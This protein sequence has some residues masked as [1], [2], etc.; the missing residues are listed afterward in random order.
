MAKIKLC[1]C[2]GTII[3]LLFAIDECGPTGPVYRLS[4]VDTAT[5]D[6]IATDSAE[7]SYYKFGRYPFTLKITARTEFFWDGCKRVF[8]RY[9]EYNRRDFNHSALPDTVYCDTVVELPDTTS[10]RLSPGDFRR[11]IFRFADFYENKTSSAENLQQDCQNCREIGRSDSTVIRTFEKQ[12]DAITTRVYRKYSMVYQGG[13]ELYVTNRTAETRL[14]SFGLAV[15]CHDY[16]EISKA[17][18]D[19][20]ESLWMTSFNGI[21]FSGAQFLSFDR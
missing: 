8:A 10:S 19:W 14:Q 9:H 4:Q 18:K 11:T 13:F 21:P 12:F 17:M 16:S 3:A 6:S 15:Y 20:N 2:T 5:I 1:V 7:Y